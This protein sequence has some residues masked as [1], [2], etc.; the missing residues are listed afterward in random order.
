MS[1]YPCKYRKQL[2][3][4]VAQFDEVR[5]AKYRR[6]FARFSTENLVVFGH[7]TSVDSTVN[8]GYV[9]T[10]ALLNF[11]LTNCSQFTHVLIPNSPVF[12]SFLALNSPFFFFVFVR[13]R[14]RLCISSMLLISLCV[15]AFFFQ[16][17]TWMLSAW[18]CWELEFCLFLSIDDSS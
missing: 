16:F 10:Q 9:L 11:S 15:C 5:P 1:L 12:P 7:G 6:M 17:S 4:L 3:V 14:L 18:V 2:P 13:C 8:P